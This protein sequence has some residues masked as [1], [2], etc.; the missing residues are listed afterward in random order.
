MSSM[1]RAGLG[2]SLAMVEQHNVPLA[3]AATP[4]L[5][6]LKAYSMG[7]QFLFSLGDAAAV[8]FFTRA[9][10]IDPQF[11]AAYAK[12]GVAYGSIGESALSAE[13]TTKAYALKGRASD[14]D[15][16]LIIAIYDEFVKGN[17]EKARE[18]CE[19]WIRAYP[20]DK[21]PHALLAG[22]VLPSSGR[23]KEAVLEGRRVIELDPQFS[24]GYTALSFALT[25][26]DRYGEAEDALHDAAKLG[27]ET[28]FSATQWYDLAFL[29][30]DAMGMQQQLVQA[31]QRAEPDDQLLNHQ[32]FALVYAG[33]LDEAKAV[34]RHATEVSQQLNHKETAALYQA[35]AA[36][37][38]AFAG[39][40]SAAKGSALAALALSHAR[41]VEYGAAFALA[42]SGDEAH[43]QTLAID[44]ERRF[45]ENTSV[46][47]SYLPVLRAMSA[48]SHHDPTSAIQ[49]LHAGEPYDLGI[50]ESTAHIPFGA[51]YTVYLR[52]QA[53]LAEG[54]GAEAAIEFQKILGHRGI[55]ISDP[56]G[57][58]ARLQLARA[59]AMAGDREKAKAS[60]RDFLALWKD[61][62]PGVPVLLQARTEYARLA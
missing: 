34:S 27:L 32:A 62:D 8:P 41:D 59:Y 46:R 21:V 15:R 9:T 37:F 48:L 1:L 26:L 10:E 55:V 58:L 52:G 14:A 35:G 51:M 30:G 38:E 23:Y 53:Y 45:P 54:R 39:D 25:N 29:R 31:Q 4:S 6:A 28:Y 49:L 50:T 43:A 17:E 42:A 13:K 16:Y 44:L 56:V 60:Y 3:E 5:E 2:E 12:L 24:I 22:F 40:A 33:R 19:T 47:F 57:A 20:R 11:A 7:E 18:D 36:V 61:A